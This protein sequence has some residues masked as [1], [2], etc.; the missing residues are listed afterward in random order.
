MITS[1]TLPLLERRPAGDFLCENIAME[2][3]GI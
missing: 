3:V 2:D 1:N